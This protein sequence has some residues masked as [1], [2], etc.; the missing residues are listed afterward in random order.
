MQTFEMA[1]A[2]EAAGYRACL[3]CRP[4]RVGGSVPW[5]A[6]EFVCRAVRLIIGGALDDGSEEISVAGSASLRGT[7]STVSSASGSYP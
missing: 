2:A 5:A 4:Y 7:S 6:P 3:S 1:A